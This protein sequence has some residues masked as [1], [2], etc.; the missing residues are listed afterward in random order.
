MA[1]GI[2]RAPGS[3]GSLAGR[4]KPTMPIKPVPLAGRIPTYKKGGTVKKTGPALVHKGEKITPVKKA[5][6]K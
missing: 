4:P 3:V 2:V 5:K 1:V 6:K